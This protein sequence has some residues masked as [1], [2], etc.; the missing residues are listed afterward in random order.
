MLFGDGQKMM[1][2]ST[3]PPLTERIRR[4]DPGFQPE[5][6]DRLAASIQREQER[7]REKASRE[8]GPADAPGAGVFDAGNIVDQI[9]KPDWNRMLMAAAIAASIPDNIATAAH[10]TEWAPEVLF[11][12]L[13][14]A[15][16]EIRERQLLVVARKMGADSEQQVRSLIQS[17]GLATPEQRLPLLEVAFPALKRRPPDFVARVLDAVKALV[18]TDGRVDVFEYLLARV[19]RMHLWDSH[20]PSQVK[21]S[22]SKTLKNLQQEAV[23]VLAVLARHGSPDLDSAWPAFRAGMV[24]LGL[25][26]NSELPGGNDWVRVLD[27]ALPQLDRLRSGD[28]EKLVNAMLKVVLHDDNV[29]PSEL[30]LLRVT[31]DLIHV[32]LPLLTVPQQI[33]P[34]S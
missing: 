23:Q 3:H 2:F 33:S 22:G 24:E 16:A 17:A 4:V 10:S 26:E 15:D 31:C 20:N 13:M 14:D 29:V 9:G 27:Q 28:K 18:E 1:L 19:I 34:Q 8:Q 5:D 6:L 21:V 30:E 7:A 25:G 32:P 11:Y 12:T